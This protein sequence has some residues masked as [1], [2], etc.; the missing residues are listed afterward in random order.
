MKSVTLIAIIIALAYSCHATLT[1]LGPDEPVL[2]NSNVTLEC[3]VTNSELNISQV[4]FEKFSKYLKQWY[5][6]GDRLMYRHCFPDFTVKQRGDSLF[7]SVSHVYSYFHQGLYR[8][9][10]DNATVV[11]NS[12]EPLAVMVSYLRELSV[13]NVASSSREF[14]KENLRVT[15][16]QDVEVECTTSS[17]EEPQYFWQ[18][19]GEDWIQASSKL[20]LKK[21]RIEDSGVYACIAKHPTVSSLKKRFN[22]TITVLLVRNLPLHQDWF[23]ST[24][25]MM[26]TSAVGLVLLML[27]L[28]LTAFLV[29]KAKQARSA[30]GP[31]DDHSQKKPIYKASVESL[32]S[33][34]GDTQ[35]LV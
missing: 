29:C 32:P 5:R 31:I 33:T 25:V 9:A 8:C 24:N 35:P 6:L 7:L 34:S 2:E 12:S 4:H 30:K 23:S 15:V 26:M 20:K 19:V 22:M 27:I 1:I 21:V 3:L 10:A 18:K 13:Y 28:L 16:G 14:I 17:S 11:D